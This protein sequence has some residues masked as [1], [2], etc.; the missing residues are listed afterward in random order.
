MFPGLGLYVFPGSSA[1]F[2]YAQ[3]TSTHHHG[4]FQDSLTPTHSKTYAFHLHPGHTNTYLY[5]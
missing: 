2:K 1:A 3:E 4:K 5:I